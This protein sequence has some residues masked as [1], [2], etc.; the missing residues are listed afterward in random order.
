[1]AFPEFVKLE[2]LDSFVAFAALVA[3]T[4]FSMVVRETNE[5]V[6][7][8]NTKAVEANAEGAGY[9]F[10]FLFGVFLHFSSGTQK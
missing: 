5:D 4:T 2:I 6:N 8:G 7:D 9:F 1:M 3:A 10:P